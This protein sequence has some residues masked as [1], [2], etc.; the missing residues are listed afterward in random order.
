MAVLSLA[1]CIT[2]MPHALLFVFNAF[3]LFSPL[4]LYLL[5]HSHTRL[6]YLSISR[7]RA[8]AFFSCVSA[9][10]VGDGWPDTIGCVS[11]L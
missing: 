11:L 6:S 1:W 5:T 8:R 4:Y 9:E 10:L 3:H 2:S 7:V